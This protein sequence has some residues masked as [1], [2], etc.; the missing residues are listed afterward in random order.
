MINVFQPTLGEEE[1]AAVRKVFDSGWI[2]R[3]PVTAEFEAGFARHLRSSP[4][5]VVSLNSCT[6]GLF[7]AM[8][9]LAV[10]PG[11]EVVLPTVSWVGAANAVAAR[12]GRPVFCDVDPRTLNATVDDV[13]AALTPRTRAVVLLH[14]GGHPGEVAAVAQLC[15]ERGIALVED[16][17][18]AVASRVDG[19]PCGTFGDLG[20]WSFDAMKIVVTG[21]GGML[22]ARDAELAAKARRSAYLGLVQ[23]SGFSQA[24]AAA[25]RWWDIDVTSFSRRSILNDIA[26]AI[27]CVQLDRLDRFVERRRAVAAHYDRE[28]AGVAGVRCPPPLPAGHESSYYLYWVQLAGGVRDAVARR[29]YDRG[30]YTTFRYPLLHQVG[31]YGHSSPLPKAEGAAAETLCL[32]LHQALTDAD[33]EQVVDE[34]RTAVGAE[35]RP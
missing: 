9:L 29:L 31:A 27:G 25:T 20:V 26:A 10:G 18:C 12:C 6:E 17:A 23:T 28:L 4:D 2:G 24:Q 13:T 22:H 5:Q 16:A 7:L 19:Q 35:S 15:R 14:Y 34:L 33:V 1:L 8:E 3:G 30:V 11:D 21:D 32:P